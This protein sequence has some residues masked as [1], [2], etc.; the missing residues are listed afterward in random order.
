MRSLG[1]DTH[2]RRAAGALT[3]GDQAPQGLDAESDEEFLMSISK[4]ATTGQTTPHTIR[5][6]GRIAGK[7]VLILVDSGSSHSFISETV[8]EHLRERVQQVDPIS[9]KIADGGVLHC[10]SIILGCEWTTQEHQFKTDLRVLSLGCYDMIVGMDWL[11]HCGPMWVDWEQKT[12]Q[13]KQQGHTIVLQGV[14][15]KLQPITQISLVQLH[16]L[17]DD[18]AVAHVVAL[19]PLSD[20]E[21][22]EQQTALLPE[23]EQL[24]SQYELVF[25]EPQELPKHKPWDHAIPL[26]AGAKRV[27]IRPYRHTPEQKTEIEKQVQEMLRAGQIVPSTSPFSS[28]VLLVKK[29]DQTWRFC[30]DFRHLNAIIVKNTYPLPIIDELLDELA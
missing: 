21:R 8:A 11:Q 18:H 1:P 24:L 30:V 17:E 23:V 4:V 22:T 15:S 3:S 16:E 7:S 14:Q 27:N 26:L 5:L 19:Y 6:L 10:A 25:S 2:C 29:K 20:K 13:F 9:V 28:P 12:L